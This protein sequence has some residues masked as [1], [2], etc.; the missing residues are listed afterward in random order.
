LSLDLSALLTGSWGT[1]TADP[2]LVDIAATSSGPV[3]VVH[4]DVTSTSSFTPAFGIRAGFRYQ[5]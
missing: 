4:N 5:F 3:G 1:A 2:T